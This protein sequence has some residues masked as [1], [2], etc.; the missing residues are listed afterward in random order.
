MVYGDIHVADYNAISIRNVMCDNIKVYGESYNK[1]YMVSMGFCR[2]SGIEGL[3]LSEIKL[4]HQDA[5]CRIESRALYK[6][7]CISK[8]NIDCKVYN[9]CDRAVKAPQGSSTNN[10]KLRAGLHP[11]ADLL[12]FNPTFHATCDV[13]F[14]N[15][16]VG[17][18]NI[19]DTPTI[20]VSY[21]DIT[22]VITSSLWAFSF[23]PHGVGSGTEVSE[24]DVK[25]AADFEKW[26]SE[27]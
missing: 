20:Y 22:A 10:V 18:R 8:V 21:S 6:T 1:S 16:T 13:I 25:L 7:K 27:L 2:N 14:N 12:K 3:L 15:V 17:T 4:R 5:T 23:N 19:N 11:I 9:H 26:R 24:Y